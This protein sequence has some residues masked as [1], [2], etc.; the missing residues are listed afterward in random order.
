VTNERAFAPHCDQ[1]VLHAPGV[2]VYCDEYSDWQHYRA[3][4][5]INFT[6]EAFPFRA[7]CPSLHFR[8][9]EKRDA[10]GGNVPNGSWHP[11]LDNRNW[12]LDE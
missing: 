10:W 2:C 12:E 5:G 6:G 4:A 8:S 11:V 9:A 3:L 1:S 7:P